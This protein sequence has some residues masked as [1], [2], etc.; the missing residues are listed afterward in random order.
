MN[1]QKFKTDT[2]ISTDAAEYARTS[3]SRGPM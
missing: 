3:H 2:G 1:K